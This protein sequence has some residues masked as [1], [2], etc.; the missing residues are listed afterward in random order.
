MA[1]RCLSE[2][3]LFETHFYI[4]PF[5]SVFFRTRFFW[6]A[7]SRDEPR[8]DVLGPIE[9]IVALI[10]TVFFIVPHRTKLHF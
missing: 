7:G 10:A 2:G 1:I 3:T 8:D 6:D 4:A 5:L 9:T